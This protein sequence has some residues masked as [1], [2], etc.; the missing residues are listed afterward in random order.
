MAQC[1]AVTHHRTALACA[2]SN[3]RLPNQLNVLLLGNVN[4]AA[5]LDEPYLIAC[6]AG[7][8]SGF[9]TGVGASA[10]RQ[11]AL[12]ACLAGFSCIELVRIAA[13]MSCLA[14]STGDLTLTFRVH[15][16]KATP[17]CNGALTAAVGSLI[18]VWVVG[19]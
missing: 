15:R 1:L 17:A 19:H 13:G 14:A 9:L 12:A 18:S 11:T 4:L 3:K 10:A 16:S 2:R 7:R 6:Q 8:Q 5:Y